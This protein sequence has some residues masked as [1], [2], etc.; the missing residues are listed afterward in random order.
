MDNNKTHIVADLSKSGQERRSDLLREASGHP[1]ISPE[2]LVRA[3]N[4]ATPWTWKITAL[5]GRMDELADAS[6]RTVRMD[7]CL[8]QIG[9]VEFGTDYRTYIAGTMP[10]ELRA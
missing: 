8:M 2:L 4:L 7:E 1:R 3:A 5:Q 9:L 10:E 6:Y